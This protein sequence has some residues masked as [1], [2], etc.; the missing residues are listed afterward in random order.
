MTRRIDV[1]ASGASIKVRGASLASLSPRFLPP[2]DYLPLMKL[3]TLFLS[4]RILVCFLAGTAVG[5]STITNSSSP[6][7]LLFMVAGKDLLLCL[8]G[9]VVLSGNSIGSSSLLTSSLLMSSHS[10][11]P[12]AP[13][14]SSFDLAIAVL[15]LLFFFDYTVLVYGLSDP[16]EASSVSPVASSFLPL[17]AAAVPVPAAYCLRLASIS[18]ILAFT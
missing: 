14:L 4:W 18:S 6:S 1:S 9:V 2:L 3:A 11:L 12:T 10:S 13:L 8:S 16:G 17:P 5:E 15:A 7:S